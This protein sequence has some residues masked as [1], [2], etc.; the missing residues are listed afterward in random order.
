MGYRGRL[1]NS[2]A[3]IL[4]VDSSFLSLWNVVIH[5]GHQ[6]AGVKA[7][8]AGK[9]ETRKRPSLGPLTVTC[10]TCQKLVLEG[11]MFQG[12]RGRDCAYEQ[13]VFLLM[14]DWKRG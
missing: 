5:G 10:Y 6:K 13:I 2:S 14:L 1:K 11:P 7:R 4:G 8:K 9:G 12:M 3:G